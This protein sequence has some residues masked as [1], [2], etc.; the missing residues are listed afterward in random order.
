MTLFSLCRSCFD[1]YH[2]LEYLFQHLWALIY[3]TLKTII[4][5]S[6]Q[7]FRI[8]ILTS[9]TKTQPSNRS[10]TVLLL[11][12]FLVIA[13]FFIRI[14]HL[15]IFNNI[16]YTYTLSILL[17]YLV[18]KLIWLTIKCDFDNSKKGPKLTIVSYFPTFWLF[19]T[20]IGIIIQ[21]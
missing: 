21:K 15:G 8:Y 19:T 3:Y 4:L 6:D 20:K 12:I 5:R 13:V 10:E 18:T 2:T 11:F 7:L 9:I 17:T 14:P 1:H 16:L